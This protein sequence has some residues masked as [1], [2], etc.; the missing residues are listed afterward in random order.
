[1]GAVRWTYAGH[2]P[3]GDLFR[4]QDVLVR[5]IVTSLELTLTDREERTLR[6]DSPSSAKAYEFYLRA[7]QIVQTNQWWT[8]PQTWSLA[9]DLYLQSV[10]DDPDFAPAWAA[11]ARV[12]RVMA[13]Y[14]IEDSRKNLD[15]A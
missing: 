5:Q 11:M 8:N 15:Q 12:Y 9:R 4:L 10:T 13:K 2:A 7:N 6:R 14:A 3:M 1:A